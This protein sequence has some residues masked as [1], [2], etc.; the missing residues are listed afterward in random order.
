MYHRGLI[1]DLR[2]G[3]R[4]VWRAKGDSTAELK[5][6]KLHSLVHRQMD[7]LAAGDRALQPPSAQAPIHQALRWVRQHLPML[8]KCGN[9]DCP[10]HRFF[11]ATG[12]ARYCSKECRHEGEKASKRRSWGKHGQEWRRKQAKGKG[13]RRSSLPDRQQR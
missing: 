10:H 1:R 6:F 9:D 2:E 4:G 7:I 5:L 13:D 11:V 3:L 12:K 8:R